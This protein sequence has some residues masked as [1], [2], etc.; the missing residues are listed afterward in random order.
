MRTG[1]WVNNT[2]LWFIT[3]AVTIISFLFA[4]PYSMICE[5]PFMNLEKYFLMPRKKSKSNIPR[6]E[7]QAQ[8]LSSENTLD[9]EKETQALLKGSDK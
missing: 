1:V 2:S 8:N 9:T 7:K 5:V 3:F 4:V 6:M